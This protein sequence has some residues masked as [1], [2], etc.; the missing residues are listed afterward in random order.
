MF[1]RAESVGEVEILSRGVR[2]IV[3]RQYLAISVDIGFHDISACRL[4]FHQYYRQPATMSTAC[5]AVFIG[6]CGIGE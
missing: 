5:L 2:A 4:N 1:C 3:L 6:D